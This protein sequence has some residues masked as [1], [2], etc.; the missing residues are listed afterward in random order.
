M[1]R[2]SGRAAI[3]LRRGIAFGDGDPVAGQ[4]PGRREVVPPGVSGEVGGIVSVPAE[5]A[6]EP[7]GA[8]ESGV[9]G[10]GCHGALEESGREAVG[11]VQRTPRTRARKVNEEV[12]ALHRDIVAV[13][14]DHGS[15]HHAG[16]ASRLRAGP[17]PAPAGVRQARIAAANSSGASD[18]TKW[19]G[20]FTVEK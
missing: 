3:R 4:T 19:P 16:R 14:E 12:T 9:G 7:A 5:V 15:G 11:G 6:T 1:R 8:G 17:A 13:L 2:G 20:L 18:R 10:D